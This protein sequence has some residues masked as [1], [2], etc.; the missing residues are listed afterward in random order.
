[1][2]VIQQTLDKSGSEIVLLENGNWGFWAGIN[3]GRHTPR[4]FDTKRAAQDAINTMNP[5][6]KYKT[7]IVKIATLQRK[8]L[9]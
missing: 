3:A 5:D 8:P 2:Y 4:R 1:M 6:P 9:T 7:C